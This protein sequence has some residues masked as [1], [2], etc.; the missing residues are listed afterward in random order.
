MLFVH[1]RRQ[2]LGSL[3]SYAM[4]NLKYFQDA[5]I[6]EAVL[7]EA[8][9]HGGRTAYGILRRKLFGKWQFGRPG[10]RSEYTIYMDNRED[11]E[12]GEIDSPV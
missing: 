1:L 4:R 3:G 10:R 12:E 9:S 5:Q 8:C 11:Y 7:D 6:L 2:K